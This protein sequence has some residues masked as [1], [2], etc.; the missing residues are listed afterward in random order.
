M[1]FMVESLVDV[2]S[3]AGAKEVSSAR[4][5]NVGPTTT[6]LERLVDR[7]GATSVPSLEPP[8]ECGWAD[9]NVRHGGAG[10]CRGRL[11][12][13]LVKPGTDLLRRQLRP[14]PLLTGDDDTGCRDTGEP[15]ETENLPEVHEQ[16]TL[17]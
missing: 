3:V 5:T 12:E 6:T 17:P 10:R 15:G 9:G 1:V 2:G 8:P 4:L 16:E 11:L 7:G 13:P 14:L